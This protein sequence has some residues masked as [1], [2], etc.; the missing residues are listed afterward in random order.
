MSLQSLLLSNILYVCRYDIYKRIDA[1]YYGYRDDEDDILEK[2][3]GAYNSTIMYM[4]LYKRLRSVIT[5]DLF[6]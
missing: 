5:M 1:S 3:E 6:C 2:L 4:V